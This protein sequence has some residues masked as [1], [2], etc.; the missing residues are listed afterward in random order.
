MSLMV[1][2]TLSKKFQYLPELMQMAWPAENEE[3]FKLVYEM[4]L[5]CLLFAVK[6]IATVHFIAFWK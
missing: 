4:N 2:C 5:S 6:K 1:G 3:I